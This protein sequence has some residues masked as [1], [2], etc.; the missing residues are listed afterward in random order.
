MRD[1]EAICPINSALDS[2]NREFERKGQ[3]QV[4][5]CLPSTE[6]LREKSSMVE[7]T[8]MFVTTQCGVASV[9]VLGYEKEVNPVWGE[10]TL[11]NLSAGHGP[12]LERRCYCAFKFDSTFLVIRCN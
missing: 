6:V 10:T 4:L 11:Y 2:I 3:S 1:G 8:S 5:I 7:S 12:I 9:E